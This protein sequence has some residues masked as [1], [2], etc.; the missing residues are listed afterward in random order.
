MHLKEHG[1]EGL[2]PDLR[3][4]CGICLKE[5]RKTIGEFSQDV[6]PRFEP[7]TY[8]IE[9]RIVNRKTAYKEDALNNIRH[10]RSTKYKS[11]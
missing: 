9:V 1:P 4:Y 5:L 7:R 3:Y 11:K 6:S 10:Q 8:K 2:W